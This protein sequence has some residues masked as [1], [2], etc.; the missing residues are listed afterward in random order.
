MKFKMQVKKSKIAQTKQNVMEELVAEAIEKQISN[1]PRN[2]TQYINKI[3]V[4]TYALN[5]LPPLYASSKEG[6]RRQK[7]RGQAE[8]REQIHAAVRQGF[9]AVQRDPLRF[10][11]P[12]M[13]VQNIEF[14]DAKHALEEL[15]DLMPQKE[16]SWRNLVE[17]VKQLVGQA[18]KRELTEHEIAQFSHQLYGWND[19][20]Y[21][22]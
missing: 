21:S 22:R 1:Y 14:E 17:L 20:R 18:A 3:E 10:S 11:T 12:L 19:Y 9:A 16:V 5:R 7:L 8:F 13:P 2:L 15:A 4:A 6:L